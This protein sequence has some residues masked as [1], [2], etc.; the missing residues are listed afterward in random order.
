MDAVMAK[1]VANQQ[2][3]QQQQSTNKA[4]HFIE[5]LTQQSPSLIKKWVI[6]NYVVAVQLVWLPYL[7]KPSQSQIFSL[8]FSF[9]RAPDAKGIF[10]MD[11]YY[12]RCTAYT[13]E[14]DF[15]IVSSW[16]NDY[17]CSTKSAAE[18]TTGQFVRG[19]QS[20]FQSKNSHTGKKTQKFSLSRFIFFAVQEMLLS[21]Y[22]V[23][24]HNQCIPLHFIYKA[25]LF[26]NHVW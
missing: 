22:V 8:S 12:K 20:F 9:F 2:Q 21:Y 16:P 7:H 11:E 5:L 10:F 3:E 1:W 26:L 6:A 14:P 23:Y 17:V 4:N 15:E 25:P 18:P 24:L 13:W 19:H